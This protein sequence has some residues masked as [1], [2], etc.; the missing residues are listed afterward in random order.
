MNTK[1]SRK[2]L[3][4][5]IDS[6]RAGRLRVSDIHE[7][8]WEESGNPDGIPVVALHGGPGGGS[9]PDMRR[10][11][12]PERYRIIIFDQ[13]GCGRSSPFSELKENTTW[14]LVSDMEKLRI[15][16]N[17]DKWVVFGGSW[18][19]TLALTYAAQHRVNTLGLVLRGIFLLTHSEIQWFYQEGASRLF[20]DAFDRYLDPIPEDERHDLV[21]AFYKRLTGD[22]AAERAAAARAWAQWEGETLSIRGPSM[23]PTKFEE[24]EF[25]DAFARIECHYFWNK[26]FFDTDGWLLDQAASFGN[27]PGVIVHGRYDVVTPLSSAWALKKVW[28]NAELK[29][30]GDAGHSSMEPGIVNELIAATEL[31]ADKFSSI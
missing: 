6:N 28:P 30:I 29:I 18:G 20:P 24:Q 13:R 7:L 25:V 21:K 15:E 16:L 12:D 4:P 10:F 17:V 14:D 23:R 9:N 8:Y 26:G 19:S 5:R 22:D 11:F 31:F 1:R 3:F 2:F 27:L